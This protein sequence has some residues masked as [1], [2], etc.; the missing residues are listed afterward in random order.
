MSANDWHIFDLLLPCFPEQ[1]N[2]DQTGSL[3]PLR[4]SPDLTTTDHPRPLLSLAHPPF[5]SLPFT[6]SEV[7]FDRKERVSRLR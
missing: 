4:L 5:L 3:Q 6:N 1:D 2:P 7:A